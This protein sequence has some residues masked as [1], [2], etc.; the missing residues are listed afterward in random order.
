VRKKG[1]DPKLDA[2]LD[3][4]AALR[5]QGAVRVTWGD[6]CAEFAHPVAPVFEPDSFA[7][8]QDGTEAA[9]EAMKQ[10]LQDH[11]GSSG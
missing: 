9:A 10:Y 2:F 5:E 7:P 6:M 3:L 1:S 8:E 11:Y 4:V